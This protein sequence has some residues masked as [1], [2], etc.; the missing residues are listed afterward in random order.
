MRIH[1]VS[2]RAI[3]PAGSCAKVQKASSTAT[4][5][6]TIGSDPPAR[7]S[8]WMPVSSRMVRST[9]SASTGGAELLKPRS[10]SSEA[11]QT[12]DVSIS[13]NGTSTSRKRMAGERAG[14][15]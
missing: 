9:V 3:G 12:K 6:I 8:I 14:V 15:D 10:G 5:A 4:C 2:P 13:A 7:T 1:A 11:I